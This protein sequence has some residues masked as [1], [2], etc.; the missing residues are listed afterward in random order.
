M[1]SFQHIALILSSCTPLTQPNRGWKDYFVQANLWRP[2]AN[3][4]ASQ[5]KLSSQNFQI[6]SAFR[7]TPGSKLYTPRL[8]Q[9]SSHA[10]RIN[11]EDSQSLG[12]IWMHRSNAVTSDEPVECWSKSTYCFCHHIL[13]KATFAFVGWTY[14]PSRHGVYRRTCKMFEKLQGRRRCH[15]SRHAID[16]PVRWRDYGLQQQKHHQIQGRYHGFQ[17]AYEEREPDKASSASEWI[18]RCKLKCRLIAA[19]L[20]GS[21]SQ[22]CYGS[23]WRCTTFEHDL[24]SSYGTLFIISS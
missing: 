14:Q 6:Y 13:G 7:G 24:L 12:P 2:A 3:K 16:L 18:K 10:N 5:E 19:C 11:R 23:N 15:F 22:G 9:A 4:R 21:L 1:V 17:D 8:L 20:F